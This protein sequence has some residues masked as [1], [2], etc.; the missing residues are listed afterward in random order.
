[1]APIAAGTS[2][3]SVQVDEL[4]ALIGRWARLRPLGPEPFVDA[5]DA[6]GGG[7]LRVVPAPEPPVEVALVSCL[8]SVL[9]GETRDRRALALAGRS[10]LVEL[11]ASE[12]MV[13]VP[14]SVR[15][16]VDQPLPVVLALTVTG[17]LEHLQ[18]RQW[19]RARVQVPVEVQAEGTRGGDAPFRAQT[20]D[21][22]GGGARLRTAEPL[23]AG[24]EIHLILWLPSGPI[25]VPAVVLE[26]IGDGTARVAFE[27]VAEA[28]AKRLVRFV[29][30]VQV[31][32]HRPG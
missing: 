32:T 25:D 17:A 26:A 31:R 12:A 13:R 20:V 29:F 18:R 5:T 6:V 3:R 19:V 22:S 11:G 10:V 27:R 21:L 16:L 7:R 2:V 28:V 15:I 30:D 24:E 14:A 4:S 23:H 8:D 1:V 9:R